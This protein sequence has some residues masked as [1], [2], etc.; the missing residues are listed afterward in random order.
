MQNRT[1]AASKLAE[2]ES[3]RELQEALKKMGL[4]ELMFKEGQHNQRSAADRAT[5]E[6]VEGLRNKRYEQAFKVNIP[7]D[8]AI[9]QAKKELPKAT[10]EERRERA[11]QIQQGAQRGGGSAVP[12]EG[13]GAGAHGTVPRGFFERRGTAE[14]S[15]G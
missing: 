4:Q 7:F 3:N 8:A 15:G 6:N 14:G 9:S 13:R 2:L 10:P 11:I 1:G 5:R 12:N